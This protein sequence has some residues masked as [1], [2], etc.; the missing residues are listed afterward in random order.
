MTKTKTAGSKVSIKPY[1]TT[2]CDRL[3]SY[4]DPRKPVSICYFGVD[5]FGFA[6]GLTQALGKI[7]GEFQFFGAIFLPEVRVVEWSGGEIVFGDTTKTEFV[8]LFREALGVDPLVEASP[9]IRTEPAVPCV[10]P[11]L[12]GAAAK[13]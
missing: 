3:A 10:H 2:D 11:A 5:K 9:A 7:E 6:L 4:F 13:G 12:P 8:R 1:G